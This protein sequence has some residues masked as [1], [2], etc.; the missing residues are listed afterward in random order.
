METPLSVVI[1]CS[2]ISPLLAPG[3]QLSDILLPHADKTPQQKFT[4]FL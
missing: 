2:W 1:V 3:L 4:V